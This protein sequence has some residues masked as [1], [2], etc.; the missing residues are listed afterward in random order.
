[1][2]LSRWLLLAAFLCTDLCL[3]AEPTSV[4]FE[5]VNGLVYLQTTVNGSDPLPFV[6][7]TGASYSV[8]SPELAK[9]LNIEAT[10]AVPSGG[11]GRGGDAMM[12]TAQGV[13][14]GVPGILLKNQQVAVLS[15]DYIQRQAGH[16]TAGILS[17]NAFANQIVQVDYAAQVVRFFAPGSFSP[18]SADKEIAF[19]LRDNVPMIRADVALP[20]HSTITGSFV[21]DS[22]LVGA[23]VF[24]KPFLARHPELLRIENRFDLPD[25]EAV[26]G[27]MK[28]QAAYLPSL[29]LG[30]V[31]IE[32]PLAIFSLN[33]AGVLD[34]PQV[35]GIIGCDVLKRFRVTYDYSH[36]RVFLVQTPP[37]AP[38]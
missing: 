33:G 26:G 6:L 25:V 23:I 31:L 2:A 38:S 29:R 34:D 1:M 13:T 7:D 37:K 19:T 12:S 9:K 36:T 15:V 18:S 35:D 16:P 8:I 17:V 22:G 20:N 5:L 3:A 28:L 32:S 27:T 21:L 11:P 4:P 14:L 10:N 30:P 24:S